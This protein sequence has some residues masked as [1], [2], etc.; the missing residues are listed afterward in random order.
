MVAGSDSSG[1]VTRKCH[2]KEGESVE[3]KELVAC[4]KDTTSQQKKI[5]QVIVVQS[6]GFSWYFIPRFVVHVSLLTLYSAE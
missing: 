3:Q 5:G 6:I 1:S 4:S 2:G